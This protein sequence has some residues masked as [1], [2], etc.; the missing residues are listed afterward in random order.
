MRAFGWLVLT[1][2]FVDELLAWAAF[3]IWGWE[4]GS[5][6]R[7]VLVWLLPGLV[8]TVWW[9]LAAPRANYG[10]RVSRPVTKVLVFGLAVLVLYLA[11]HPGW[12]MALLVFT[13]VVNGLALLPSIR[14]LAAGVGRVQRAGSGGRR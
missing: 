12:A 2:V 10:G 11:G 8:I 6:L 13:V 4:F 1:L 9:L 14:D 7:W 5:P 3:G